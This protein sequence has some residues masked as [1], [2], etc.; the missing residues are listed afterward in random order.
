MI[1]EYAVNCD[2][3]IGE[4]CAACNRKSGT[5][6]YMSFRD[7]YIWTLENLMR[8]LSINYS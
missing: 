1:N 2:Q 7:E 5:T 6:F 8:K 3:G 4:K